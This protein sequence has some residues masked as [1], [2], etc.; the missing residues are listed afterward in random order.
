MDLHG[1]PEFNL[2]LYG[3]ARPRMRV[4]GTIDTSDGKTAV[5]GVSVPVGATAEEKKA[6]FDSI[7]QA[8][9]QTYQFSLLPREQKL[10]HYLTIAVQALYQ[11][12]NE[13]H[14]DIREM[15]SSDAGTSLLWSYAG[16]ISGMGTTADMALIQIP[17]SMYGPVDKKKRIDEPKE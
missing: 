17:D 12:M 14:T 16:K 2:Q 9:K 11:I 6:I 13:G 3:D 1:D 4:T 15:V 5:V 8:E 10:E 7:M